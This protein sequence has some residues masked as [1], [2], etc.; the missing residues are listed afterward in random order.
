ML[1]HK[2]LFV[3][4]QETCV[5][6]LGQEDPWEMGMDANSSVLEIF[7]ITFTSVQNPVYAHSTSQPDEPHFKHPS[8]QTAHPGALK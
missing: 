2:I 3:K 5:R 4:T 1:K 7:Y 8:Y 6:C